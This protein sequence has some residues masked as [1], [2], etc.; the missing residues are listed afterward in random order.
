MF[1]EGSDNVKQ[2]LVLSGGGAKGA[3]ETGCIKALQELNFDFDIVTGTSIGAFNGL[4]VA[5]QDYDKLYHLWDT[6][7]IEM[8][9]KDPIHFDLSIES[10]MKNTS[11]IKPFVKSFMNNKGADNEPLKQL[12]RGLFDGQKAKNSPIR[13]GCCTVQFPQLKPVEISIDD[14]TVDNIIEY[15][16]A[17]AEYFTPM[18]A[19]C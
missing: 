5:Q 12:V 17:S 13:Y 6:L 4:L 16:I 14:M 10:L 9:L 11:L 18:T 8:V 1:Y 7:S 3:Y 19:S 15:A 2:A